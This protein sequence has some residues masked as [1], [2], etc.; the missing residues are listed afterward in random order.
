MIQL[1]QK[2]IN[3]FQRTEFNDILNF[4]TRTCIAQCDMII[5]LVNF[6]YQG[7]GDGGIFKQFTKSS[8]QYLYVVMSN[9]RNLD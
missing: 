5:Y 1:D 3:Y 4:M 9:S 6:F 8:F 2:C 7:K